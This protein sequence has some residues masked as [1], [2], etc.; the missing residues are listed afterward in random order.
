MDSPSTFVAFAETQRVAAGELRD[1]LPILKQRFERDRTELVLV[2][3][4]ESG[5]Q[6]EFDLRGP[7]DELLERAAPSRPRGPGRPRLGVVGREV[8]LMPRH[9]EWLER[10]PNGNSAALRRLVEQALKRAPGKEHG[11]RIRAALSGFLSSMAGDRPNYEEVTRALFAGDLPRLE[12]LVRRWPKDVRE[13]V[14][15]RARAADEQ[16]AGQRDPAALVQELYARVWTGADFGQ[17]ERLVAADYVVHSDPGDPWEGQTLDHARY[18][19]RVEHARRALPDLVV[20]VQDIV[21]AGERVAVRWSATGT[22]AG[23]QP[24]VAATR[25]RVSFSGQALYATERGRVAGHWQVVDRLGLAQ[26]LG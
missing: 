21:A 7:L 23:E 18:R 16:E 14:V 20:E 22:H 6:V 8:S 26:Q 15:E 5:R 2:F 1:V 24:G 25:K 11:R 12:S 19:A 10:Q 9:W 4:V 13:F 17:I 3:E